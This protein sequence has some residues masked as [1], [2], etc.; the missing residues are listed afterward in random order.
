MTN[1]I[2]NQMHIL[3]FFGVCVCCVVLRCL[4]CVSSQV[5][6]EAMVH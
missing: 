1:H 2:E 4:A 5:S 3:M 6:L